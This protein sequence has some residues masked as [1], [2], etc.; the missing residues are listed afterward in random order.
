MGYRFVFTKTAARDINALDGVIRKKLYKKLKQYASLKDIA[1]ASKRLT[2]H[3]LGT[4]RIR[5]G[6]Y[7][8]IFDLDGS[9][10]VVLR[11]QHRKD[12]YR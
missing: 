4:Y 3:I 5:I 1:S 6:N 7:R 8:L 10:V 11:L 9:I 2:N 12:V